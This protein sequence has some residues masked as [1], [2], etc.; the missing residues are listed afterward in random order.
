MGLHLASSNTVPYKYNLNVFQCRWGSNFVE[1]VETLKTIATGLPPASVYL[2][3]D[4][5][6]VSAAMAQPA[7]MFLY[8]ILITSPFPDQLSCGGGRRAAGSNS[9]TDHF[10]LPRSTI[11]RGGTPG[12]RILQRL[13]PS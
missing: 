3:I 5:F 11:M 10:S 9:F 8:I 7:T 4:I 12:C 2:W 6:S 1:L 13:M